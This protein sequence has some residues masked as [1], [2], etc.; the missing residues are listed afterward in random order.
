MEKIMTFSDETV[1]TVILS[2]FGFVFGALWGHHSAIE[3]RVKFSD[4]TR[5][6]EKCYCAQE[7]KEIKEKLDL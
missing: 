5:I 2:L 7:I 4:C 3:K 1:L 6:R